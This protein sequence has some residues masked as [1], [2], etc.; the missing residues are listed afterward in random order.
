METCSEIHWHWQ[1]RLRGQ[2]KTSCAFLM[3]MLISWWFGENGVTVVHTGHD[4][5]MD[6]RL[7]EVHVYGWSSDLSKLVQPIKAEKADISHVLVKREIRRNCHRIVVLSTKSAGGYSTTRATLPSSFKVKG[8]GH[9]LTS[10]VRLISAS[11]SFG[12]ENA[13]PVSLQAGGAYRVGR[14]RRPHFLLI[15]CLKKGIDEAWDQRA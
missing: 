4:K 3:F 6:E 2:Q 15:L 14:T 13:V 1:Y 7:D 5:G 9:K 11:S 10:S 8:Q 12:K